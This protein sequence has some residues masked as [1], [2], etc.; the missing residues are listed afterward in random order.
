MSIERNNAAFFK[1]AEKLTD[2]YYDG[3]LRK[4]EYIHW[5][6]AQVRT[7]HPSTTLH[8]HAIGGEHCFVAS[9]ETVHVLNV[10]GQSGLHVKVPHGKSWPEA[11]DFQELI[12]AYFNEDDLL[13]WKLR[14]GGEQ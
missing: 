4:A 12:L 1:L 3:I 6:R 5:A 10:G 2:E 7:S 11:S 13:L 9:D 14:E 8:I